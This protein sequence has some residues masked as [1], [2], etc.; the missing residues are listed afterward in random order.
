MHGCLWPVESI[1][2]P[3]AGRDR[4]FGRFGRWTLS[5]VRADLAL[6]Q[7]ARK[8]RGYRPTRQ[9]VQSPPALFSTMASDLDG[10]G[11]PHLHVLGVVQRPQGVAYYA[12]TLDLYRRMYPLGV[13]C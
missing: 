8:Q 5:F 9:R 1:S 7:A 2:Q 3:V 11:G 12:G 6:S 13:R 10:I 4:A